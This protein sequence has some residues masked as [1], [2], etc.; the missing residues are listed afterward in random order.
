M[1]FILIAMG[2]KHSHM[3]VSLFH[4]WRV[5]DIFRTP[6]QKVGPTQIISSP[7]HNHLFS[8]QVS[9]PSPSQVP[10][11]DKLPQASRLSALE[12]EMDSLRLSY[13]QMLVA[14]LSKTRVARIRTRTRPREICHCWE[15]N[16]PG[17]R[18]RCSRLCAGIER[19]EKPCVTS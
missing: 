3:A 15:P 12:Y 11:G 10:P 17:G 6:L 18:I 9:T 1:A 4:A 14:A 8:I 16:Q 5:W 13:S 2:N 7:N 19:S